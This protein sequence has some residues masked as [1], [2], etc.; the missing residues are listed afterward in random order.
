MCAQ[1]VARLFVRG[2]HRVGQARDTNH[3]GC[4]MWNVSACVCELDAHGAP[5]RL[6][7]SGAALFVIGVVG[8][9]DAAPAQEDE[10]SFGSEFEHRGG[11]EM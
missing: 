3:M 9:I 10:V 7:R 6:C 11:G 1:A 8:R 4:G 2:A 5:H